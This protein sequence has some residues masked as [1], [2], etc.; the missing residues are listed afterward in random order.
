MLRLL[1]KPMCMFAAQPSA[2]ARS[3]TAHFS[4]QGSA[5]LCGYTVREAQIVRELQDLYDHEK[6]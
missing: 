1:L 4:E 5:E 3:V 2:L 6:K